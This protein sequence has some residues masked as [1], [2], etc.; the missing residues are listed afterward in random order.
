MALV[1]TIVAFDIGKR[2]DFNR[3]LGK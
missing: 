1:P 2:E 3:H